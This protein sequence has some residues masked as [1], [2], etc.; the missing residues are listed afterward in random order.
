MGQLQVFDYVPIDKG[1]VK[2]S[3]KVRI[4]SLSLMINDCLLFEKDGRQ[5]IKLPQ[6]KVEKDGEINYYSHMWFDDKS[7]GNAFERAVLE[8]IK[9]GAVGKYIKPKEK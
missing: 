4:P 1:V 8:H 2:G 9:N 7:I 3:F 6:K 5:W